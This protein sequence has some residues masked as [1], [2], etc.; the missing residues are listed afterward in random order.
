MCNFTCAIETWIFPDAPP[1]GKNGIA[2]FCTPVVPIR[3]KTTRASDF[4]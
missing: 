2:K 1:K 4:A 3:E